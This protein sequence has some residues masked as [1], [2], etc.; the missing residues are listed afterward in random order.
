[1]TNG[2]IIA[3]LSIKDW[4]MILTIVFVAGGAWYKID[5]MSDRVEKLEKINPELI[6]YR[7]NAIDENIS[8]LKTL[9][10]QID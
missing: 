1:M 8:E 10:K 4:L 6:N 5:A 7:L 2:N 9:I 3:K